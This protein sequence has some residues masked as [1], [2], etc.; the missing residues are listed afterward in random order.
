MLSIVIPSYQAEARIGETLAALEAGASPVEIIVVD[1]G[2]TDA[3]RAV[4][5]MRG[6]RVIDA[7]R[8]R[9]VQLAAGTRAASGD[10][11]L[12]LHADTVLGLG[13]RGAVDA[14]TQAPENRERAAVFR[15]ALD[16]SSLQARRIERLAA[17]R[18]RVLKLPYGDQGLL[19]GR[20]FYD[21]IGGFKPIPLMEDVDIVRRIGGRRLAVLDVAAVTSAE[22]YRKG[23]FVLRPVHNL[24]CLSFYFLGVPPRVL[25]RLYG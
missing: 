3:T 2:S 25:A 7:P 22:R 19:I 16:D 20:A 6:A 9:G 21:A 18:G 5:A 15:F 14:F 4:A 24:A 23:G 1:G 8:G 12:F 17:W 13:W 10:W 11:L